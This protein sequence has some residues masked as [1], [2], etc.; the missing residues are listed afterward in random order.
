V[1]L[2]RVLTRELGIPRERIRTVVNRFSKRSAV[3]LDDIEKSLGCGSAI[4]VP[5]EYQMSIDSIDSAVPMFE[6]DKAGSVVRSLLDLQADLAGSARASRG[7]L[8]G[9]IPLFARK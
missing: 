1:K 8:L 4:A 5:N 6:M 3:S 9:R 7:G 2:V